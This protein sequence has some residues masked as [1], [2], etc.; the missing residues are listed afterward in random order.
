MLLLNC[1]CVSG[2]EW[3]NVYVCVFITEIYHNII[4]IENCEKD[5]LAINGILK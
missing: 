3:L 5:D 1:V 2:C 4:H